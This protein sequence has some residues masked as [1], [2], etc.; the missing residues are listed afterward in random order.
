MIERVADQAQIDE[1]FAR[2]KTLERKMDVLVRA[3]PSKHNA[4]PNG[5]KKTRRGGLSALRPNMRR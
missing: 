2:L 4:R 5:T 3:K 1:A